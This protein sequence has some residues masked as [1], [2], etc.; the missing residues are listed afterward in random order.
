LEDGK[1]RLQDRGR[2]LLAGRAA[3]KVVH[4]EVTWPRVDAG[5]AAKLER[6]LQA[7]PQAGIVIVD[8]FQ[9]VRPPHVRHADAY[10]EDYATLSRLKAIADAFHVAIVVMHHTRKSA[11]EDVFD[12]LLGSAG[13]GGTAD[14][15]LVSARK[16]GQRDAELHVTAREVE[17]ETTYAVRFD[18][19]TCAWQ[20]LGDARE[21]A[22]SQQRRKIVDAIRALAKS[23]AK[24]TPK[25]IAERMGEPQ[26]YNTIKN[27]I[28]DMAA[29]GQLITDGDGGYNVSDS[30]GS[31]DSLEPVQAASLAELGETTSDYRA[32]SPVV[33]H[34][35]NGHQA[36][37]GVEATQT[38]E[39]TQ[40]TAPVAESSFQRRL[41]ELAA[42][43][44]TGAEAVRQVLRER[45]TLPSAS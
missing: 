24:A 11:A 8:V 30:L 44:V 41:R 45:G 27:T 43:G 3:P 15:L 37:S 18:E 42:E 26:R 7:H 28:L 17:R 22:L 20:L 4:F 16:R 29:D 14:T 32:D 13:I 10:A 31:L 36:P 6:W 21:Y 5:G 1:K 19:A 38:T 39:T 35:L 34:S 33:S 23:G 25:E 2:K 9:R 40:T 12:E